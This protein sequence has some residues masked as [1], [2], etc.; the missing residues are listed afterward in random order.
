MKREDAILAELKA[1]TCACRHCGA[2]LSLQ[3]IDLGASPPS[4]AFNATQDV[5]ERH[6]PLRV[7]V[8]TSCWLAQTDIS[9]FELNYDQLFTQEYPYFSSTSKS[10]VEHAREFVEKAAQRFNLGPESLVVEVGSN[11]GYLLQWV[12]T[13]CYG[14]EPTLT[15]AEATKKG[16]LSFPQFF[17]SRWAENATNIS[18]SAGGSKTGAVQRFGKADLMICNNVLAHVPDVNDFVKGFAT[19]LK[20]D[21]VAVFEFPW[22]LNLIRQRQFDTI[23]HEHYSYLSFTAV[24]NILERQGLYVFDVE[25]IPTHGGS[26]R[27]YCSKEKRLAAAESAMDI[28]AEEGGA[29][30]WSEAFYQGFQKVAEEVKND[31]LAFLLRAKEMRRT[32]AGFGAAAKGNTLLNFTGVRADLI[33]HVVDET[34]AKQGKFLPGSRIPVV[35]EF[36][37]KPDYIVIFPWNFRE[38]ITQKLA[39]TRAWGAKL[40]FVI[41]K[42]EIA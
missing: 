8:C 39:Y 38:E 4:N 17:S 25:K 1:S 12:K 29:G 33:S 20:D 23:Y 10:W 27:V 40:V 37:G 41:P 6:Y 21:G 36:I 18:Y 3:M 13:P 7:M 28:L 2:S 16:I 30:M 19:L 14:V 42:L 35:P 22:L 26:L 5:Q 11:D 24:R 15:G 32:V 34:P 31:F 9:L